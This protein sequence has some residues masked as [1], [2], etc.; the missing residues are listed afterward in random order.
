MEPLEARWLFS[1]DLFPAELPFAPELPIAPVALDVPRHELIVVDASVAEIAS[2]LAAGGSNRVVSFEV[3]VLD[4]GSDG[5]RQVTELL[6]R[7]Q[8][9]D[10]VHVISHGRSGAVQLGTATLDAT[11]LERRAAELSSWSLALRDDADLLF[12]GCDVASGPE[13]TRFL[14]RLAHLTG[15]DISA[16]DDTTGSSDL[17][18][19][20]QLEST[21]GDV[22]PASALGAEVFGG[23]AGLLHLDASDSFASGGTLDG[24]TGGTGWADAWST[25]D[26]RLKSNGPGLSDPT[27]ALP[28]SGSSVSGQ[29]SAI[30]SSVTATRNLSSAIGA[31][32]TTVWMS[33]L[34]QPDEATGLLSYMGLL[35]GNSSSALAY[36]GYAGSDFVLEQAGGI[37]R[38]VVS[39]IAPVSGQTAFFVV[40]IDFAAGNDTITTYVNPTPGL[41]TPDSIFTAT[42]NNLNLGSFT[43]IG[44]TTGRGVSANNSGF[45][46]L[47][48]GDT[49][50]DVAPG[51]VVSTSVDGNASG[52][53]D[54]NGAHTVAW[55][56][57]N[58]GA[59]VSLREAIIAANN[60]PGTQNISFDIT[61]PLVGGVHT[62]Y[63]TSALPA[64]S[65][66]VILN[67]STEP[68]F[69]D[70]PVIVIDGTALGGS[71][72]GLDVQSTGSEVHGLQFANFG[73]SAISVDSAA[74]VAV[75]DSLFTSIGGP[76]IDLGGNGAVQTNDA[77][78][79]DGGANNG[80]NFP[81]IYSALAN[82]STVTITGEARPG[83]VA[84]FFVADGGAIGNG[85]ASAFVGTGTVGATGTAG[86]IDPTAIRFSFTFS[87]G[88]LAIGNYVSA[89]ATES[90]T[91]TSEFSANVAVTEVNAAPVLDSTKSPTL[92]AILEDAGAPSGAVGTLVSALVDFA[93]PSGQIDNI[94]DSNTSPQLGIAVTAADTASGAW[95]Y[96][97]NDGATWSALGS[98]TATTARLLAADSST[99]LYFQPNANYNGT[100]SS[101][102][103]F[104]AWDRTSGTAGST[105]NTSTN[106]GTTAF[107][108]A[109]DT[110]S[111][112]VTAVD[113]APTIT[114]IADQTI[115]EDDSTRTVT[116]TVGDVDNSFVELVLSIWSDDQSIIDDNDLVLSGASASRSLSFTP[117]AN[118]SGGPVTIH[119]QMTDGTNTTTETFQI[120]VTAQNDAPVNSAPATAA[121]HQDTVLVFSTTG[122]TLSVS[123]IDAGSNPVEVTITADL[124]GTVTL[125]STGGLTLTAGTGTGD[126]VV[127][128][129][130]LVANVNAALNGLRYQPGSGY[131]GT[132][133]LTVTTSD[134]GATGTGGT[135][136]DTD[137][138]TITISPNVAATAALSVAGITFT[139][140]ATALAL[141]TGLTV[142]DPDDTHLTGARVRF[143]GGYQNGQ[144]ELL[145]TDQSG[146]TGTWN[147][148]TGALYLSGTASLA[149][150][151]NALRSVRY[152]NTS[153]APS[154]AQRTLSFDLDDGSGGGAAS[155]L[156]VDVV[157]V[158][159]APTLTLPATATTVEDAGFT[160]SVGQ[161]TS[162]S[163]A[164]ADAGSASLRLRLTV[165][166]GTLTLASQSGLTFVSG[167]DG[168]AS[169]TIDGMLAD[170][171][172]ALNGLVFQAGA[173]AYGSFSLSFGVN[174]LGAAGTG[175]SLTD[176]E[177]V[178]IAVASV[179]DP[180]TLPV[181]A[182]AATPEGSVAALSTALLSATDTE[183][184][185]AQITYRVTAAPAHGDL[186]RNGAVLTVGS[187][188]TQSDIDAGRIAYAHDGSETT[189]DEFRFDVRDSDGATIADQPFALTITPVDDI[190]TLTP[191]SFRVPTQGSVT[192]TPAML[193]VTDDDGPAGAVSFTVRNVTGGSFQRGTDPTPI[194]SF[195]QAEVVSGS[196]VFVATPTATTA[197]F[198]I[199]ATDG[200]NTTPFVGG[201]V[202]LDTTTLALG[203]FDAQLAARTVATPPST[204]PTQTSSDTSTS[205]SREDTT[206]TSSSGD[207]TVLEMPVPRTPAARNRGAAGAPESPDGAKTAADH[208][209][210]A[211]PAAVP[212]AGTAAVSPAPSAAVAPAMPPTA[213]SSPAV[214]PGARGPDLDALALD[215][216]ALAV[217]QRTL[218]STAFVKALDQVAKSQTES[219]QVRAVVVGS[220]TAVA[221]SLSVG[222]ILWLMRG[223]ALAASLLASLPAWRS[224]D[225]LPI[226][227]R[228]R[229]DEPDEDGPDDPLE[230][231]FNRA[232]AALERRDAQASTE[233]VTS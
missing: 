14:E 193:A 119:L 114:A 217:H 20:W 46:E 206:D 191:P 203:A 143:G 152:R 17:G 153:E 6:T 62:L 76:A 72:V 207:R 4:A 55:L 101:A 16:S 150:Y 27:G 174:D 129:R 142:S 57:A 181:N 94:T 121:T 136:A 67:G 126:T 202:S 113:D 108:T 33:F 205:T 58:R 196:I 163:I 165:S 154:T 162:V 105:A 230:K 219:E 123:D 64:L 110:A 208:D 231:L 167:A 35:F 88:S 83:T 166:S 147:A 128:F 180:L 71:G 89:T 169:M 42:K 204:A 19:N 132:A 102:I 69:V 220:T 15:A 82:G 184:S 109:T 199:S 41:A 44:I 107:S 213:P 51:L 221:S 222:Y 112:T 52:I 31:D 115:V 79:A 49:Y 77:G 56:A 131:S 68:D 81:V 106:G 75:S 228:D 7:R 148:T 198:E 224:L 135:Q 215:S 37:G 122:P 84:E 140:G 138:V 11:A 61:A 50:A 90:S 145:F 187:V 176:T 144:D 218:T 190:L 103:T 125:G 141:D 151:Q 100:L 60:T 2:L 43:E 172:A 48:I 22:R 73:R 120:T 133:S 137:I 54:G 38:E 93:T 185:A 183:D 47:R 29:L 157:S 74:T 226:L 159:D 24:N 63:V 10:A 66:G 92:S 87:Q 85:G 18:G 39:G 146:I 156:T 201:A 164:D 173:D 171:N 161:G 139:E 99:R 211:P 1:A 233:D 32:G 216:K 225:P 80:L 182:G 28:V 40:R 36:T 223:G 26:N 3:V 117:V 95:W 155:S 98:P 214:V 134:L 25:D 210:K 13:G 116:F 209:E 188:F 192:L 232:R 111:L 96:S 70:T 149:D 86:S 170:L 78:D 34:V 178:S 21:H 127:T 189:A 30:L 12:Y 45:D 168:T 53:V 9:L 229:D 59:T 5:I 23:F 160:F 91:M 179:N 197:S 158:N 212:P 124:G 227:G 104:R 65:D 177:A 8:D 200:T 175:G 194:T 97:T 118:A 130:G 195:T 186:T